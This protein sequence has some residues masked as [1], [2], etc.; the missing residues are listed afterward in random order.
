M[1]GLTYGD[2]AIVVLLALSFGVAI[3]MFLAAE[4][5]K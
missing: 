3:G 5:I 4:E 2:F 1:I